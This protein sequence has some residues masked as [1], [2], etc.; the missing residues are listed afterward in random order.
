MYRGGHLDDAVVAYET[1]GSLND[2]RDNAIM[3]FTGLSPSAHAAASEEDTSPGWWEPM[4]GPDKPLDTSRYFVICI[5]AL[6]SCFGSTGPAS[7]KPGGGEP[8]SLDFPVLSLEDVANAAHQ[9]TRL[10]GIQHL[11]AAVGPSMGGMSALAYC[12]LH[13][14][15]V[16]R[17][18]SI[19][20]SARSLP[21]ATAMRSLTTRDDSQRSRVEKR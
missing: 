3:L 19:S 5:N 6:G 20:S 11:Y 13:A 14:D 7:D 2:E 16:E 12:M 4:V 1:W 15:S 21:F 10:L 18:V 9:V 8:Y 17:L